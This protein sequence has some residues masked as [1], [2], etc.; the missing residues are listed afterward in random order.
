MPKILKIGPT[1]C[2]LLR[3]MDGYLLI[4]TS[5]PKYL[6]PFLKKLKKA[7][8]D[9]TEIKYLLL[10]HAHDDHAGFAAELKERTNCRI[11]VHRSSTDA[12]K[13][14]RVV[15]LGRFLNRRAHFMMSVIS[16]VSRRTL[17]YSP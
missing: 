2:Y 7:K 16:W 5:L 9:L 12:L 6:R 4:D 17:K 8:V 3:S 10:T 11:I 1:N 15:N 13:N 14:G